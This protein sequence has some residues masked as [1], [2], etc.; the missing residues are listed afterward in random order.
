MRFCFPFWWVKHAGSLLASAKYPETKYY[1]CKI[2]LK[3]MY[4]PT[5]WISPNLSCI[6]LNSLAI[7]KHLRMQILNF[8][9]KKHSFSKHHSSIIFHSS[10]LAEILKLGEV[11]CGA[12]RSFWWTRK[13]HDLSMGSVRPDWV[14]LL[15]CPEAHI[16]HL[17]NFYHLV[18][19]FFYVCVPPALIHLIF[20]F[21]IHLK[22]FFLKAFIKKKKNICLQWVSVVA[23]R[24]I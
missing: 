5:S 13:L 20:F 14:P 8:K 23:R 3:H 2:F 19:I 4:I 24:I 16:Y 21:L 10:F 11:F 7:L 12:G 15:R 22:Y 1:T 17:H 9:F 6:Y 18:T